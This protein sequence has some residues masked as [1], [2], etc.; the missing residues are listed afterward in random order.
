M[1]SRVWLQLSWTDNR[2]AW[3]EA[4]FPV[5]VLRVPAEKIWR[6]DVFLYNSHL[7]AKPSLNCYAANAL[8]YPNGKIWWEP[9]CRLQTYCNLTLASAPYDEQTC[10]MRF[11]SRTFDGA[12]MGLELWEQGNSTLA[13]VSYFIN[14]KYR[15]TKNEAIKEEEFYGCYME[16]C[17]T[18]LFTLGFQRVFEGGPTCANH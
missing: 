2:F 5:S 18:V 4:E 12:M 13:D 3:N 11:G 15:I 7:R 14:Q 1:D 9:A 17:H 16:P 8:V 6:P 10:A